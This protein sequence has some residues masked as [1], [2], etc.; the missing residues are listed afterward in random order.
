MEFLVTLRQD[1]SA[2]REHPKLAELVSA[3]RAVGRALIADG[4]IARI[5]RLPGQRANVGVWRADDATDLVARLD[6]LPLR[7]WLDAE[8]IALAEHELQTLDARP[9]QERASEQTVRP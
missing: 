6:Q 5:W 1:W 3:E 7:P 2:L 8:V 4:T 9:S